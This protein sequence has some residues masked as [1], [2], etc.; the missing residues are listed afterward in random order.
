MGGN[1]G[2]TGYGSDYKMSYGTGYSGNFQWGNNNNTSSS[3]D[4]DKILVK[5]LPP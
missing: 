2:Y 3:A 4:K 5:V 1:R